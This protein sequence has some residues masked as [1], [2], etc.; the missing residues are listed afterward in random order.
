MR[1]RRGVFQTKCGAKVRPRSL[2]LLSPALYYTVYRA[3]YYTAA[4]P[5]PEGL[6]SFP[7]HGYSHPGEGV[8][9]AGHPKTSHHCLDV[10]KGS[11][12][13]PAPTSELQRRPHPGVGQGR[14]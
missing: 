7:G 9:Y 11:D 14:W 2:E 12:T 5:S 13:E 1:C 8:L 4:I 3:L 6:N 10:F